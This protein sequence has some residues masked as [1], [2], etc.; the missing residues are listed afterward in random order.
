MPSMKNVVKMLL[1]LIKVV[2][3]KPS[4][5]LHLII[6]KIKSRPVAHKI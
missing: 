5:K 6:L 2:N 4:S 3:V 1:K